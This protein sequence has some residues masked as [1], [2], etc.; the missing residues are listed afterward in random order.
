MRS[1]VGS[2]HLVLEKNDLASAM[3]RVRTKRGFKECVKLLVELG[4][5]CLPDQNF[6]AG[7]ASKLAD[8]WNTVEGKYWVGSVQQL[9]VG[10]QIVESTNWSDRE[11][12]RERGAITGIGVRCNVGWVGWIR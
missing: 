8:K 9:W 2:R 3:R 11:A 10:G 12:E 4:I 5:D 6:A 1:S 7:K